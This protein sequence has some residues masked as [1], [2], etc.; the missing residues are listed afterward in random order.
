MH[1]RVASS[2]ILSFIVLS[3]AACTPSPGSIGATE[4]SPQLGLRDRGHAVLLL[5]DA[6]LYEREPRR[7]EERKHD[8]EWANLLGAHFGSCDIA[9]FASLSTAGTQLLKG[10]RLLVLPR[11][12]LASMDSSLA[13][14]LDAA[15]SAGM[16]V[17]AELPDRVWSER[18]GLRRN[19][20]EQRSPLPWPHQA[21]RDIPRPEFR[22]ALPA[23]LSLGYEV[24]SY[25]PGR[26]PLGSPRALSSPTGRPL[27]WH[28]EMGA[29]RWILLGMDFAQLSSLLRQGRLDSDMRLR[30]RHTGVVSSELSA[31]DLVVASELLHSDWPWLDRWSLCFLDDRHAATPW[32]RIWPCAIT[33]EG[34]LLP[35]PT[36]AAAWPEGPD[37]YFV[38]QSERGH[39]FDA[40]FGADGEAS[41]WLFGSSLPFRPLSSGGGL[42]RIWEIPHMGASA[43]GLSRWLRRNGEGAQG[44]LSIALPTG[45]LESAAL[46][47]GH[48]PAGIVEF[49][50]FW[51][52]RDRCT[53]RWGFEDGV[54]RAEFDSPAP[55]SGETAAPLTVALPLRWRDVALSSWELEDLAARSSRTRSFDRA[56]LRIELPEGPSRLIARYEPSR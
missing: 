7:I 40:S 11:H 37:L 53:L 23:P 25:W 24:G 30:N 52:R 14:M 39:E 35:A 28:Y 36:A 19:A 5:I 51:E 50:E 32:P 42:H 54:L 43:A 1:R 2:V 31:S 44:P 27:L 10:R 48:R 4:H 21:L 9:D 15:V 55:R 6:S 13:P 18:I 20:L 33:D 29:G 12:C 26:G 8:L 47:R 45:G 49:M 41:G 38:R 46:R 16:S 56:Y 34:W 3:H 17:L 22:D